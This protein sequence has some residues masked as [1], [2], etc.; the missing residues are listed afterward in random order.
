MSHPWRPSVSECDARGGGGWAGPS[1]PSACA[2]EPIRPP[3][4]RVLSGGR[5]LAVGIAA[6]VLFG[7]I[8][9]GLAAARPSVTFHLAPVIVAAAVAV[10]HRLGTGRVASGAEVA[11]ASAS[12]AVIA[13]G[14]LAVVS[15]AGLLDGP[16]FAPFDDPAAEALVGIA[17]G[18]AGGLVVELWPGRPAIDA[19]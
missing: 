13:G 19:E 4:R 18:V 16:A 12:G 14:A 1:L 2:C 5:A 15:A 9:V 11:V 17:I 7:A 6:A 8:W 10:T 3:R